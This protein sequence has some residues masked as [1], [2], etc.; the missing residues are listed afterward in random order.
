MEYS[1]M[2][3]NLSPDVPWE[4]SSPDHLCLE[5]ML[6]A[7]IT[8]LPFIQSFG[9]IEVQWRRWPFAEV[10]VC[11]V[12]MECVVLLLPLSAFAL[13]PMQ[14]LWFF[15]VKNRT[16]K[17]HPQS[18]CCGATGSVVSPEGWSTGMWVQSPAWHRRL[19]IWIATAAVEVATAAWVCSLA[20]DLHRS[21][22]NQKRKKVVNKK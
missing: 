17:E 11:F 5:N 22:G 4:I 8:F 7:A 6:W 3:T 21:W 15:S 18:S 1:F 12:A 9:C 2:C 16:F 20:W 10:P 13:T 14:A 19:R